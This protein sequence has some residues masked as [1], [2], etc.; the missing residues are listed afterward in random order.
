MA[1]N[2][3]IVKQ[4]VE[5]YGIKRLLE[6]LDLK[7]V[8][9]TGSYYMALCPFHDNTKQP[10]FQIQIKTGLFN[11]FGCDAKGN[12]YQ[13]VSK[14]YN[15]DYK[16]ASKLIEKYAGFDSN[17]S[18]DD[19]K[20]K[21][22]LRNMFKR[23]EDNVEEDNSPGFQINNDVLA[24]MNTGLDPYKYLQSRGF[25]DEIIAYFE[26]TFTNLWRVW[27][28]EKEDYK[29]EE[30]VVVPGHD[31]N[32]NIIG[33]IGRTPVGDEP[34]YRYTYKYPKSTSLFNLHRAK[35]HT[36]DGLIL[37]EGSLDAMRIHSFGFPN[38]CCIYGASLS[39]EQISLILKYTDKVYLGFDNDKAG[40]NVTKK[41][42]ESLKNYVDLNILNYGNVKDPG[43]IIDRKVFYNIIKTAP[44]LK[45][46][47]LQ[48]SIS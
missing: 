9:K 18:I 11:C 25:S 20:F 6:D 39:D 10:D 13:F 38:V 17:I 15:I 32:G 36:K 43:D 21:S 48:S 23:E 7:K 35:H 28:R 8:V 30:R 33:F 24:K 47:L 37:V 40:R 45:R 44:N 4:F 42:I 3:P 46:F 29:F 22:N 34:K 27:N 19:I 16:E 14:S 12:L 5:V 41:A 31:E 26:C 2:D 1:F